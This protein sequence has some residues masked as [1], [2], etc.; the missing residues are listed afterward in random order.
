MIEFTVPGAPY[1]KGRGQIVKIGGFSRIKTPDKTVNYEGLVRYA[2]QQAMAGRE[3]LQGP[4]EV[5]LS[6][7]MAVPASWSKKRQAMA[8][9]GQIVPTTK[10]DADNCIKAILDACN[11]VVWRDDVQCADG[12]WRKRYHAVP[13]VVV[14]IRPIQ[15]AE[16]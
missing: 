13:G 8:L 3:L 4:V 16:V 14:R 10:P 6:I 9:A 15:G 11:G 5:H 2:A 7:R 1:G 12:I